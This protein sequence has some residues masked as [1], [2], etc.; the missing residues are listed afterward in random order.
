MR[1]ETEDLG[2]V[3]IVVADWDITQ[4]YKARTLTTDYTSWI[5]YISR[6]NVPSNTPITD[7]NYWKPIARLQS[8]LAIDYNNFK[9]VIEAQMNSLKQI[10]ESFLRTSGGTALAGE[11]GNNDFIGVNQRVLT[12]AFNKIWSKLED[13]TGEHS[14]GIRMSITPDYFIS[15]DGANVSINAYTAETNG[16]FEHIAFYANGTLITEADNVETFRYDYHIEDTTLI[17]C[18][19]KI[20]GIEYIE[21]KVV[22]HYN[23]FWL[24]AG[25]TYA[26]VMIDSNLRPIEN[27]MKGNYDIACEQGHYF[28]VIVA[29]SLSRGYIRID[30]N[31]FEI[32]TERTEIT[33]EGDEFYVFKSKNAYQTS[34]Y[35][36]DINS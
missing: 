4:S 5:T 34:T 27:G 3:G 7:L 14:K 33:L 31:G 22:T 28:F 9:D 19:A 36:I 15:E 17:K 1:T 8:D 29:K 24:G 16:I 10:V 6:K 21:Q 12:T 11:F 2:N 20:M 23:S 30:M 32:P 35:N 18:V 25:A 13:I 26:N